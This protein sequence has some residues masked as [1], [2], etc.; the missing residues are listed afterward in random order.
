MLMMLPTLAIDVCCM[1]HKEAADAHDAS[2]ELLDTR[3]CLGFK[4]FKTRMVDAHD[5]GPLSGELHLLIT[6]HQ[7]CG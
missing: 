6:R 3:V 4:G 1:C 7:R 5:A 2:G